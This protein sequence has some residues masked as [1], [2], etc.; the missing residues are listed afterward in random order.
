MAI[1]PAPDGFLA[2]ATEE[3]LARFDGLRFSPFGLER[4]LG[5]SQRWVSTLAGSRDGSLWV[6]T[7][8]GGV[9]QFAGERVANQSELRDSVFALLDDG[10][11]NI[12]ASTRAG[13]MRWDRAHSKSGRF[14]PVS[15]LRR[16]LDTSWNVLS[17]GPDGSVWVVTVDG[18][19]RWRNGMVD[20]LLAEHSAAGQILSVYADATGSVWVG[21]EGG[22]YCLEL[23]GGG[24]RLVR[25]PGVNAPVVSIL[26]DHDGTVWAGS[27][28]K[29][30]YRVCDHRA[31]RWSAQDGF[32][33][34][35]RSLYE[36][37]EGDLWIGTRS[38][39]LWRWRAGP[40]VPFGIPEGLAGNFATTVAPGPDGE[41]WFGTWR[42]GLYRLHAGSFVSEPTPVPTLYCTIRALAIDRSGHQWI[43]NWEGLYGFDG[44]RYKH[45]FDP[46]SICYHVAV[47][48]FDRKGQL[49][50]GT[51]DH[52][53]F[54]FPKGQP[55][56]S[57]AS[58]VLP[59]VEVTALLEDSSG[60][61]W[62]GTGQGIRKLFAPGDARNPH[63]RI[64]SITEDTKHRIWATAQSGS[65]AAFT[66]GSWMVFGHNQGV[67][68]WPL[69]RLIDDG[70]G[71]YWV[72]T[73]RGILQFP[74]EQV[75]EFLAGK[76][77][78]L[79][80]TRH[81]QES[82]MRTLECHGISQPA[83]WKGTLGGVWFPTSKGFVHVESFGRQSLVAPP[84]QLEESAIDGKT[85][86]PGVPLRL[87]A[88]SRAFEIRYTALR[89]AFPE[90]LQFRYRME[91]FD[92]NW[93]D[94]GQS[95]SARYSRLPPG[96]YRFLVSARMP[97]G[98]WCEPASLVVRQL[99]QFHQTGLFWIVLVVV[100]LVAGAGVV[101]WRVLAIKG[102]HALLIGERNRIAREWHDTLLAGFAAI[103]WQLD[104]ALSRLRET[105]ARAAETI[106]LAM[107][108]V[109]HY[110]AEARQVI[111][112]LREN[113][114][115]AETLADAISSSVDNAAKISAG[116]AVRVSGTPVKLPEEMER[117]VLRICQEAVLNARR[118]GGPEH[119]EVMLDYLPGKLCVRI[120]DDGCGFEPAKFA[121]VATGHFGL[122]VMQE[123]AQRIGGSLRLNSEPGRGTTVEA[124]IPLR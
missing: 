56:G 32:D 48:L 2:V 57:V 76:R 75:D 114:P 116:C 85:I 8:D 121:G 104:E 1:L 84:V 20:H 30:L 102:R 82:G 24:T 40:A 46:E 106:Q 120:Q 81:G 55:D 61:I 11:G 97:G 15:G 37:R 68:D 43:G 71:S 29:G 80:F 16:P 113:R 5:L 10:A 34:F 59:G 63:G 39:G 35:I 117:N 6:G 119:I 4:A 52:G 49:W 100:A 91:G 9:Y 60:R 12:W 89:F 123:R 105:P 31:E 70:E 54:V 109:N 7:F 25:E 17:K 99:P 23:S 26:K 118:H 50:I 45:Y 73:A 14:S 122:A 69:Y 83:G 27:W 101:R 115:E 110:R 87:A 111:W 66:G 3:G 53:L 13:V 44:T 67:P 18:L 47:V 38:S 72:S 90:S 94:A 41:L 78:R 112:D 36:D 33:D 62:V 88:S 92:V 28:G 42:G 93:N 77:Q 86:A 107:K 124:D 58:P 51:S 21:G 64:T 96:D 108:M 98:P 22:L 95:R 103:S 79:D 65:L 74:V 19:F